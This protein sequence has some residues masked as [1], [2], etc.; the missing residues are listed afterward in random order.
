MIP[1]RQSRPMLAPEGAGRAVKTEADK[2]P[3]RGWQGFKHLTPSVVPPLR[4]E[5]PSSNSGVVHAQ[6]C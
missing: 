6:S 5:P 3:G 1:A 4:S 2:G